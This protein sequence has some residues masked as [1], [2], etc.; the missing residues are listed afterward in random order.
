MLGL[1]IIIGASWLLLYVAGKEHLNCLGVKPIKKRSLQ[2]LTGLFFIALLRLLLIYFETQ[3]KS[4]QWG[5]QNDI[6]FSMIIQAFWYHLKSALTED[7][8]FR[9]AVLYLLIKRI[10]VQKGLILSAIAFGIY[11]WF[12][13]GMIGSNLVPLI[14]VL[15]TTGLTGYVWGYTFTK[16]ESIMMPLGFHLGWNFITTL[17]YPSQPYGQL[18]YKELSNIELSEI[19]NLYYVIAIGLIPSLITYLFVNFTSKKLALKNENSHCK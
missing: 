16:T 14:Y 3:V 17:F 8:I 10:G 12:S 6:S 1:L 9:G 18:L 4:I 2:F 15:I 5:V 13:Y 19:N 11:H 7:L